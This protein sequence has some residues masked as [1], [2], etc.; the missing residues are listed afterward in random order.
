MD[1]SPLRHAQL[2]R[3]RG[4]AC[5]GIRG[6]C[7]CVCVCMRT[8]VCST[9]CVAAPQVTLLFT[10][11]DRIPSEQ[12]WQE[13]FTHV[14]FFT[15]E[16]FNSGI[17]PLVEWIR[18]QRFDAIFYPEVTCSHL[19][20]QRRGA[21]VF[22]LCQ[23]PCP[24]VFSCVTPCVIV[25]SV[26]VRQCVCVR[27]LCVCLSSVFGFVCVCPFRSYVPLLCVELCVFACE[28]SSRVYVPLCPSPVCVCLRWACTQWCSCC[29]H[30]ACAP[31]K[32]RRT[33]TPPP[34]TAP[35]WTTG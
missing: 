15:V 29:P 27:L 35:L 26:T 32:W 2:Q 19:F 23:R 17:G 14:K 10:E 6:V 13:H 11:S 7:A 22:F 3:V 8:C 16:D 24:C 5:N 9:L 34:H 33:A 12:A 25:H 20:A 30:C 1:P 31:C 18:S 4:R 21:E 28:C